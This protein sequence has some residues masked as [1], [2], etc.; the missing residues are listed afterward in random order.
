[1]KTIDVQ[2]LSYSYGKKVIYEDLNLEINEG[3]VY[4]ILGKNGVGK[5]T[6]IN[7]LMGYIKPKNGK[8][9]IYGEPSFGISPKTRENIA[10]LH[11]GY[12]SLMI[13][14]K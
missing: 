14:W 6:L 3:L 10:L 11:E 12:L 9:L 13:L 1:M 8:C 7:I 5:S 2:N 4:G